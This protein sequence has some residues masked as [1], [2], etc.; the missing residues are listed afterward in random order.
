M[1]H[2]NRTTTIA[3]LIFIIALASSW[4]AAGQGLT[5]SEEAAIGAE[6]QRHVEHYY[7]LYYERNPESLS[8]EIFTLPWFT[9]G[10]NG[11]TAR[12]TEEENLE[13]FSYWGRQ[14]NVCTP[15]T[16]ARGRT[17]GC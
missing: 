6:A 11:I 13:Y 1:N 3:A 9:M 4:P 16:A 14:K 5:A 12:S 17:P 2:R 10:G 8:T 7:N 15:T